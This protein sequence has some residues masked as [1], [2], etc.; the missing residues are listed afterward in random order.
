MIHLG[1]LMIQLRAV[2]CN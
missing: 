1:A 2:T